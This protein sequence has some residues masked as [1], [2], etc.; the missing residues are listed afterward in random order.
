LIKHCKANDIKAIELWTAPEGMGKYLYTKM[1]FWLVRGKGSG[2][3]AIP[4]SPTEIRMRLDLNPGDN[5]M[6]VE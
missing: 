2:F 6:E 1:G 3:E 5:S 4:D